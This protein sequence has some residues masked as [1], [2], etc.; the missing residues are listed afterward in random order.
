MRISLK[1]AL[2]T[3]AFISL[4]MT[5]SAFAD[6]INTFNLSGTGSFLNALGSVSIS[7]TITLDQTTGT[8]TA[9]DAIATATPASDFVG[10]PGGASGTINQIATQNFHG[11]LIGL[12]SIVDGAQLVLAIP[13]AAFNNLSGNSYQILGSSL[14]DQI[15]NP[16][17]LGSNLL[18]TFALDLTPASTTPPSTPVPEP[19]SFALLGTGLL[20]LGLVLRKRRKS[21]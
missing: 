6:Q 12:S 1:T 13:N 2:L 9:I 14:T 10:V 15:N 16:T 5:G 18:S 21:A 20:G 3:G 11:V 19:G 17:Y 4:A 8:A 7:G